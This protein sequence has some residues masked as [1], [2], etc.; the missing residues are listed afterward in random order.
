MTMADDLSLENG[1][2]PIDDEEHLPN[3]ATQTGT[4]PT[5]RLLITKLVSSFERRS[6]F[7]TQP[8]NP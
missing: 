2:S 8:L 4:G 5:P 1:H 3:T 6:P 7:E